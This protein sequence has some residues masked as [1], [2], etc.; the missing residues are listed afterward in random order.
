[1]NRILDHHVAR[2][3]RRL[4][5]FAFLEH[6]L[7]ASPFVPVILL[8]PTLGY[9]LVLRKP[10]PVG[11][12]LMV[13]ALVLLAYVAFRTWRSRYVYADA[14]ALLDSWLGGKGV[15]LVGL[16]NPTG[17][18]TVA[19]PRLRWRT[20]LYR[21]VPTVLATIFLCNIPVLPRPAV[22]AIAAI[23]TRKIE[24][25]LESLEELAV[26]APEKLEQLKSSL[27]ELQQAAENMSTE[28]FWQASDKLSEQIG[29]SLAESQSALDAAASELAR[30]AGSGTVGPAGESMP[31]STLEIA[32]ALA[33]L[34]KSLPPGAAQQGLSEELAKEFSQLMEVAQTGDLSKLGEALK[35][36]SPEELAQLSMSLSRTGEA[37]KKAG[38]AGEFGEEGIGSLSQTLEA[39]LATAF[40]GTGEGSGQGGV[41]RGPGTNNRLFGEESEDLS[42]AMKQALLPSSQEADPGELLQRTQIPTAPAAQPS[43]WNQPT[44]PGIAVVGNQQTAGRAGE[45]PPRYRNAVGAYFQNQPTTSP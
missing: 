21:V 12:S 10:F 44:A 36:L 2:V 8:V 17:S 18:G 9:H 3:R 39:Q 14:C 25:R 13:G 38:N 22:P 20:T 1:M 7:A 28:E 26:L 30:L 4:N 29:Q 41:T 23:D 11:I 34:F 45:I 6:L 33:N 15:A 5:T 42:E 43:N 37:C 19:T 27:N 16:W 35:Q 24:E 31:A 40:Y 32:E